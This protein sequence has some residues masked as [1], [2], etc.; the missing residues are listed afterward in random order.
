MLAGDGAGQGRHL[1][2]VHELV[3]EVLVLEPGCGLLLI[4]LCGRLHALHRHNT[5]LSNN[6]MTLATTRRQAVIATPSSLTG[7]SLVTNPSQDI[8]S[9][10]R[11]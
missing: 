5:T 7:W 11:K 3:Q 9:E 8:L 4:Q 1:G 10:R 2:V 6:Q